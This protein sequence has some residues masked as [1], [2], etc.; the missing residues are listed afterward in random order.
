MLLL[1]TYSFGY[2][3]AVTIYAKIKSELSTVLCMFSQYTVHLLTSHIKQLFFC[4]LKECHIIYHVFKSMKTNVK[5]Y[6]FLLFLS[7]LLFVSHCHFIVC[8]GTEYNTGISLTFALT[9]KKRQLGYYR[10]CKS[11]INLFHFKCNTYPFIYLFVK[12]HSDTF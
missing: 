4:F 5:H 6:N 10:K 1:F 3:F 2:F 7:C 12:K 8:I 11:I 9:K